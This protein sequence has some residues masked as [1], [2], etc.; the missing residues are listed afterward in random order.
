M[1]RIHR[2][3]WQKFFVKAI[4]KNVYTG[5]YVYVYQHGSHWAGGNYE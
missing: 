1:I 4:F 3:W 5:I 2:T